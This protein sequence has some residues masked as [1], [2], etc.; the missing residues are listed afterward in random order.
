MLTHL[1]PYLQKIYDRGVDIGVGVI[2][3]LA[4]A[5]IGILFWRGKLWLELRADAKKQWQQWEIAGKHEHLM[6]MK[7]AERLA[8]ERA[9]YA[10]AVRAAQHHEEL[11]VVWGQYVEWVHQNGL[12]HLPQNAT[13]FSKTHSTPV[14][15]SGASATSQSF[16]IAT[17]PRWNRSSARPSC[18]LQTEQRRRAR[19]AAT[20]VQSSS[21]H[22]RGRRGGC[23]A[24]Q[25]GVG[26]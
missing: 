17:G 24:I 4:L 20:C 8:E 15:A 19:I 21:R 6:A 16:S 10:K 5:L 9:N 1:P 18:R 23:W 12:E 14:S 7:K 3:G 22:A 26:E 13:T 11:V 25:S 2:T